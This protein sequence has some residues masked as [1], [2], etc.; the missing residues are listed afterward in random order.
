MRSAPAPSLTNAARPSIP[1]LLGARDQTFRED[2][3]CCRP[4]STLSRIPQNSRDDRVPGPLTD[5][6]TGAVLTLFQPG[7]S[8]P[9]FSRTG[10]YRYPLVIHSTRALASPRYKGCCAKPSASQLESHLSF[11]EI[12]H[13]AHYLQVLS[14]VEVP[15]SSRFHR[16]FSCGCGPRWHRS[17]RRPHH[18]QR[19]GQPRRVFSPG[20]RGERW[21]P[22]PPHH[23]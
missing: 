2:V 3:R 4:P 5:A 12:P 7:K 14:H 20:R 23:R 10:A 6:D 15:I 21:Y 1:T 13:T 8:R 22:W 9:W 18:H 17:C 11:C 16:C 19:C